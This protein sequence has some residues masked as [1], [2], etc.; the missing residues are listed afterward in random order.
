MVLLLAALLAAA[1]ARTFTLKD[2][3]K[4]SYVDEG[5]G[6]P[7]LVF[8]H[9]GN[10]RKEIWRE[11]LDAFEGSHRVVAMDLAGHGASGADR[12]EWTMAALG[13]DV[14]ALV[15]H[16]QLRKVILVG[17]SLG[18]PVSL[19]AARTLG[20]KRV[21]GIVAVDT[22]HDVEFRWP[23]ENFNQM[24]AGY[25]KDFPNHCTQAM[26][27][28][29]PETTP[30]AIKARVDEETCGNDPKAFLSLFRTLRTY[31]MAAAMKAAAVPVWAINA[32]G[33]PTAPEINR[34]HAKS[35]DLIL[36][37]NVGHYPQVEKPAEFQAHLRNA[38]QALTGTASPSPAPAK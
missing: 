22:L 4:M 17:N 10:C 13:A 37:E 28:L 33:F 2:G 15:E 27:R 8:V 26:L 11:T 16:L 9:C 19:E 7:A 6:E 21:L 32:T 14:A 38:V 12:Q 3:V 23:E 5:K 31:D 35:F 1:P 25:E 20:P 34:K 30:A 36:M 29:V 18:G 24:I